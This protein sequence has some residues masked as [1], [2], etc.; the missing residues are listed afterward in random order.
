MTRPLN[1]RTCLVAAVAGICLLLASCAN[2]DLPPDSAARA[3]EQETSELATHRKR[4]NAITAYRDHLARYPDSPERDRIVRRLADLLLEQASDRRLAATGSMSETDRELLRSAARHYEY[5]LDRYPDGPDSLELL[6]QL[7]RARTESGDTRLALQAIDRLL[8]QHPDTGT[9]LYADTLFRQGELLFDEGRYA[10]AQR[11]YA[12]LVALG[13]T[14]PAYEHA[15]YKH[16]W[17]L[18]RQARYT[19]ALEVML[20]YLERKLPPG[21]AME[22]ERLPPTE[23][24]QAAD[25]LRVVSLCLAELGGMEAAD[26][27]LQ[28]QDKSRYRKLVLHEL[29]D[30]YAAQERVMDAAGIWLHLARHDPLDAESPRL[31]TRAIEHYE[32]AGFEQRAV[33]TQALFAGSYGM[34]SDFWRHHDRTDY[35][36]VLRQLQASLLRLASRP[37]EQAGG[38]SLRF[39]TSFPDHPD[40]PRLLAQAG[41]SLL[42]GR[43]LERALQLGQQVLQ[44]SA[45]RSPALA[46]TALTLQAQARFARGEYAEAASAYQQA[47][48]LADQEDAQWRALQEGLAATHYR[49][50]EQA[51]GAGQQAAA[52]QSFTQAARLATAPDLIAQARYGIATVLLGQRAWADAITM[53]EQLRSAYPQHPL[54]GEVTR[55]LA[56]ACEQDGR[57]GQAAQEYRQLGDDPEQAESLRREALLHAAELYIRAGQTRQAIRTRE[58]YLEQFPEP[59]DRAVE[60]MQGLARLEAGDGDTAAARHWFEE[61]LRLDHSAGTESTR[62]AAAQAALVLAEYRL[63]DF[64]RIRLTDPVQ[65]NLGRKVDAMKQ[66]LHAFETAIDYGVGH[67]TTAATYWIA[68]MY[69]ELG[70]ALLTSERPSSLTGRELDEYE[71]LLAE[72]AATFAR[73]A[74]E[75]H[76]LNTQI[77]GTVRLDPWVGRSLRRLSEIQAAH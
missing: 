64:R 44:S 2:R 46:R 77:T 68:S 24:I 6:Y 18:F 16:G 4:E 33:E 28:R 5:L 23:R 56:Y 15:L 73:K 67:V 45:R 48:L 42:E 14:A 62:S 72:Q 50:A 36:D 53:L 8:A 37:D 69:D 30:Q 55:K 35:P 31:L 75:I 26:E 34:D 71:S 43:D 39:V 41:R 1:A 21:S 61:I 10:E 58:R 32:A 74:I 29:A 9:K 57:I 51:L 22:L 38:Y 11:V 27:Y 49:Q 63:A 40:A 70:H 7:S 76:T 19:E 12:R 3:T 59:V 65:A 13:E 20:A 25:A 66:A 54:Q 60:T 17:S 47:I 52:L